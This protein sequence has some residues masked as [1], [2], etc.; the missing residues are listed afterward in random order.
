M[1]FSKE[2]V[3]LIRFVKAKIP[4]SLILVEPNKRGVF[5][6]GAFRGNLGIIGIAL[7]FNAYGTEILAVASLYMALI[8]MIDNP[9]SI[10]ILKP[11][12]HIPYQSILTNPII[13][14][15][16]LGLVFSAL[17]VPLPTFISQSGQYLAQMTL[18]LA[19]ICIGGSLY[20]ENFQGHSKDVIWATLCKLLMMPLLGTGLAIY[21]GFQGQELGLIYLVLSSPTA[22]SSYI[23]AKKLT[24]H[25]TI[26]AEIIALSTGSSILVITLG[27]MLL[28]NTGYL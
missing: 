9:L 25:G 5:I 2:S 3:R 28:Q 12:G 17:Q 7:V 11:K 13:I 27:L 4:I 21:L 23:M 18:P 22:V 26:A 6:Q 15:V 24:D 16:F 1:H 14:A 19:L 10:L 8:A 20:W